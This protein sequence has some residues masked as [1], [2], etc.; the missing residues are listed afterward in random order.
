MSKVMS[1][2]SSAGVFWSLEAA[3]VPSEMGF[4]IMSFLSAGGAGGETGRG[5]GM[6]TGAG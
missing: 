6:F 2:A 5:G 1:M 3:D 4:V